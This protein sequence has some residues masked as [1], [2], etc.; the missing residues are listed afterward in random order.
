MATVFVAVYLIN[1]ANLQQ[2]Y[3]LHMVRVSIGVR[4]T[5]DLAINYVL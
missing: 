4:F 5:V 1:L 3:I 2:Q